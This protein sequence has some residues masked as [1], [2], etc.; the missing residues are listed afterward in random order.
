MKRHVSTKDC[1]VTFAALIALTLLTWWLST[2][3]LGRWQ[4]PVALAIASAKTLL[5]VLF[6][7]HLVEQQASN[8]FVFLFCVL[9]LVLLVG[10]TT[11]D[12]ATRPALTHPA[13]A[14]NGAVVPIAA[15]NADANSAVLPA[16]PAN[17][18]ARQ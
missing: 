8:G 15:A 2:L 9:M 1:L 16:T 7:M 14:D 17:A 11:S 18:G 3:S 5:I 4:M 12:V 6:F 10:L 13:W